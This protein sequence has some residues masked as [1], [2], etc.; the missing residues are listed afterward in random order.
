M[1]RLPHHV[2]DGIANEFIIKSKT[3]TYLSHSF[4]STSYSNLKVDCHQY[5]LLDIMGKNYT[6]WNLPFLNVPP[7]S[8]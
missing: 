6:G 4:G 2:K 3:L 5:S 1:C 8:R 7:Y